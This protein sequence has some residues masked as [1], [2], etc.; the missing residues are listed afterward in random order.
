V[1][2][3]Q[4]K[5]IPIQYDQDSD[6]LTIA[7][8]PERR[9]NDTLEAGDFEILVDAHDTLVAF[10]IANA[11]RF[12]TRALGAGVPV[13]GASQAGAAQSGMVW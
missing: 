8:G 9:V 3:I 5:T 4:M 11:S 10:K 6:T 12:L 2:V 1:K 7:L 13:E